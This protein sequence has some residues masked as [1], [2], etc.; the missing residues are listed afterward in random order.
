[1]VESWISPHDP[2]C[3]KWHEGNKAAI[4]FEGDVLKILVEDMQMHQ[5]KWHKWGSRDISWFG[6][7][8]CETPSFDCR[9]RRGNLENCQIED[10][11]H[12]R[13]SIQVWV[14]CGL[15]ASCNGVISRNYLIGGKIESGLTGDQIESG[16]WN[17]IKRNS[18]LKKFISMSKS[19]ENIVGKDFKSILLVLVCPKVI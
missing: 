18:C 17:K 15:W 1:M 5:K 13:E 2:E 9:Y 7:W 3:T 14:S 10:S 12:N 11:K 16:R 6:G 8:S 4:G 19:I